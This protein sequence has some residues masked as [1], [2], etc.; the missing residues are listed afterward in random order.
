M[1]ER[2]S[3]VDT[4]IGIQREEEAVGLERLIKHYVLYETLREITLALGLSDD[5][6]SDRVAAVAWQLVGPRLALE[7][8]VFVGKKRG[9]PKKSG[10]TDGQKRATMVQRIKESVE[11]DGHNVT[12]L[13]IIEAIKKSQKSKL[14]LAAVSSLQNSVASENGRK[15]KKK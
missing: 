9:R 6:R 14:F 5:L 13:E 8:K 11:N 4:L 1:S 3:V 7:S 2:K 12:T 10:K 15:N